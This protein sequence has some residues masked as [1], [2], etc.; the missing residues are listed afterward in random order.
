MAIRATFKDVE[1]CVGDIVR[2]SQRIK[3]EDKSHIQTFEGLVIS[4]KG[5]DENKMFT[6]RK[7]GV[8]QIGIE[9]IFPLANI[10]EKVEVVRK[11]VF[12]VRR[13]KLYYLRRK[14]KS[15]VEKIFSRSKRKA[16]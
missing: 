5:R 13:A 4:I 10:I 12:G 1:F 8:Q 11:G 7:I 14:S 9:R 2:V 6:L 15:E 3:E 16:K